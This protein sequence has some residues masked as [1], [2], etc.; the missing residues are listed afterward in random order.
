MH[1]AALSGVDWVIR[2]RKRRLGHCI[3]MD[4]SGTL[5]SLLNCITISITI[6]N[7]RELTWR[8]TLHKH[9]KM[10]HAILYN[11]SFRLHRLAT[12]EAVYILPQGRE[13]N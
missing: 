9:I 6:L 3:A 13:I 12:N 2:D 11:G 4:I 8:P 5:I 7:T 1:H 10:L